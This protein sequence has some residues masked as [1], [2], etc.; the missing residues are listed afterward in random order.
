MQGL[1]EKPCHHRRPPPTAAG[2][3]A[4]SGS[5]RSPGGRDGRSGYL[6]GGPPLGP[7][8]LEG[9]AR[10]LRP[11]HG[12]PRLV[13]VVR[14]VQNAQKA[15][16]VKVWWFHR[17]HRPKNVVPRPHMPQSPWKI[18]MFA[19]NPRLAENISRKDILRGSSPKSGGMSSLH[20]G[21]WLLA[22]V[23]LVG[24]AERT[25]ESSVRPR[26]ELRGSLC[27]LRVYTG[28][29]FWMVTVALRA[30]RGSK[31]ALVRCSAL[32]WKAVSGCKSDASQSR[33]V[34]FWC[35]CRIQQARHF[36]D[37]HLANGTS[38]CVL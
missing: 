30:A 21:R 2:T 9:C 36:P 24:N 8:G 35:S 34:F 29:T 5:G 16:H 22:L 14:Y 31:V 3:E 20:W 38:R 4:G 18:G 7:L 10:H 6:G 25:E 26:R 37:T 12:D 33:S 15:W 28:I 11:V 23:Q 32:G 17:S 19:W 1:C 27:W 13:G